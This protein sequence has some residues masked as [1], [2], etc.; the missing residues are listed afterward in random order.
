MSHQKYWWR[1]QWHW[2]LNLWPC[3]QFFLRWIPLQLTALLIDFLW[4]N[5]W[6]KGL[7]FFLSSSYF[8]SSVDLGD[9]SKPASSHLTCTFMRGINLSPSS[10]SSLLSICLLWIYFRTNCS[11]GFFCLSLHLHTQPFANG[12]KRNR[13][14]WRGRRNCTKWILLTFIRRSC[15]V[16]PAASVTNSA[17]NCPNS[18]W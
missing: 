8:P 16:S 11:W 4:E 15:T 18:C 2:R 1:M 6:A 3:H 17:L 5:S 7:H 12:I 10:L 13:L 9:T 14:R